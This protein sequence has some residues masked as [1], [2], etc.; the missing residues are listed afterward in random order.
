MPPST[1]AP[2]ARSTRA[3]SPPRIL[4][5][6]DSNGLLQVAVWPKSYVNYGTSWEYALIPR[7]DSP[8][9]EK[10]FGGQQYPGIATDVTFRPAVTFTEGLQTETANPYTIVSAS[11]GSGDGYVFPHYYHVGDGL[12][13]QTLDSNGHPSGTTNLI[14]ETED[15]TTGKWTVK[16]DPDSDYYNEWYVHGSEIKVCSSESTCPSP[17]PTY[18]NN[19]GPNYDYPQGNFYLPGYRDDGVTPPNAGDLHVSQ[20]TDLGVFG[21]P[22]CFLSGHVTDSATGNPVA[23]VR[24]SMNDGDNIGWTDG[25]GYYQIPLWNSANYDSF[26]SSPYQYT[27][28][29]TPPHAGG[30]TASGSS[31]T[32][33]N[34]NTQYKTED[35]QISVPVQISGH[36]YGPDGV[37]PLSDVQVVL[38]TQGRATYILDVYTDSAG[39]WSGYVLPEPFQIYLYRAYQGATPT[40][41]VDSAP[42]EI[43]L[44]PYGDFNEAGNEVSPNTHL[45]PTGSGISNLDLVV[46]EDEITGKVVDSNGVPINNAEIVLYRNGNNTAVSAAFSG[47]DGSYVLPYVP[48]QDLYGPNPATPGTPYPYDARLLVPTPNQPSLDVRAIVPAYTSLKF[49]APSGS[50]LGSATLPESSLGLFYSDFTQNVILATSDTIPPVILSGPTMINIT[51]TTATVQWSTNKA[52]SSQ[53]SIAPHG[54]TLAQA[55]N[56]SADLLTHVESLTGL[57]PS[58]EYD[59]QVTSVD[60]SGKSVTS[61]VINFTT[62]AV[63][64][65]TPPALISDV[66]AINVTDTLATITWTTDE[67][68][69][70]V[71][72][73]GTTNAFGSSGSTAGTALAHAVQLTGLTPNTTYY[74]DASSCDSTGAYCATFQPLHVRTFTTLGAPNTAAPLILTGPTV[75]A[76]TNTSAVI[77]WTTDQA[78]TSGVSAFDANNNRFTPSDSSYVTSH[79]IVLSGPVAVDAVHLCRHLGGRGRFVGLQQ[80]RHLRDHRRP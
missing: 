56:D 4:A 76:I 23:D 64:R 70:S 62:N 20:D 43:Y 19:V 80:Q 60:A 48:Y 41:L 27:M 75:S 35:V 24:L 68:G 72:N 58:T 11:P 57:S 66:L 26:Q 42:M 17:D 10:S 55:V 21:F 44:V 40:K 50:N 39:G 16:L 22:T 52:A 6:S 33:F 63:A 74:F 15:F 7:P 18:I 46:P 3:T 25:N 71:A 67:P 47:S 38:Y 59:L 2:T 9:S 30:S 54:G 49:L 77:S 69:T 13:T 79:A 8:Y 31:T 14:P 1:A 5:I 29:L 37:T 51:T 45:I 73:Y 53:V 12:L 61:A 28:T 34:C 65:T 36:V 32:T 78:S